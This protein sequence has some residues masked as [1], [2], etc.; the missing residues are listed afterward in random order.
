MKILVT[1]GAGFI[2]SNFIIYM[3]DKYPDYKIINLDKLTYAGNLKNLKNVE[4]NPNYTFIKGDICDREVVKKAMNSC[5]IVVHFAAE[6]HVDRSI[7]SP[8]DFIKTNVLGTEILLEVAR[9]LNIKRFHHISTDEVFGTLSLDNLKEKFNEQSPYSPHSPYSASKAGADH[10]VRAFIETYN[11][12][13][14]ISNCT[15]NYGPLQFPE[16]IIP[17]FILNALNN[18]PLPIYGKGLAV[19]DYL[20]VTDHC[21]AIDLIIHKGKIGETYCIGGDSEKN[22]NEIADTILDSLGK[23]KSLKTFVEDRKGHDMRYA[24]DHSK[25][26]R[27]LG[28]EPSVTFEEG[29]KRTILW[30]KNKL[31]NY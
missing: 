21:K 14:T 22:G 11:F 31:K 24:M 23:P 1:G 8:E 4:N 27:E 2:G 12:P 18:K 9:E 20:Y 6:S 7:V 30:Y 15:N 28:W 10:L 17:L 13:A 29:I 19:R 16:K 5:D 3:M 25:I 26:T